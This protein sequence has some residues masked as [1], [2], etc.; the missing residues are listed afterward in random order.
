M[1]LGGGSYRYYTQW[2]YHDNGTITFTADKGP[3][4]PG[5]ITVATSPDGHQLEMGIPMKGFL[6]DQNGVPILR[7]GQKIDASFS[8][9][10]S[11]ELAPDARHRWAS[12]TGEP[13]NGYL[14]EVPAKPQQ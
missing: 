6:V 9:E 14:I 8:L 2:S 4:V 3:V 12:D 11:G 5:I 13:I 7:T 10:A 1:R